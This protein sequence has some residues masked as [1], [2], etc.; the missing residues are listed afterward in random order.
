MNRNSFFLVVEQIFIDYGPGWVDAWNHHVFTWMS[1]SNNN[2]TSLFSSTVL[3]RRNDPIPLGENRGSSM[4]WIPDTLFTGC[5]Y[6]DD[7]DWR[8][9]DRS[10][11]SSQWT[12]LQDDEILAL[13]GEDGSRF[14]KQRND[15]TGYWPCLVLK[16]DDSSVDDTE[17]GETYIV[18]IFHSSKASV[19]TWWHD[20]GVPRFLT[21]YPRDS[22]RYFHKPYQSDLFLKGA[23]RHCIEIP[24]DMFPQHWRDNLDNTTYLEDESYYDDSNIR[25]KCKFRPGDHVEV[26]VDTG[27]DWLSG[28]VDSWCDDTRYYSISIDAVEYENRTRRVMLRN[29]QWSRTKRLSSSNWH[30]FF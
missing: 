27:S 14:N 19:R 16:K 10:N 21:K 4:D 23:F 15:Y 11:I 3:N 13:F 30:P 12:D 29:I 20:N 6:E 28:V 22:I 24:D 2:V 7:I 9:K 8:P 5:L 18:R 26:K 25:S 1:K 17:S